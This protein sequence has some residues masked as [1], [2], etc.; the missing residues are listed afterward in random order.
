MRFFKREFSH[1]VKSAILV[2]QNN[3]TAANVGILSQSCGSW[4][5]EHEKK[6][7][8]SLIVVDVV[9]GIVADMSVTCAMPPESC[10]ENTPFCA[11]K[12]GMLG[13]YK[14]KLVNLPKKDIKEYE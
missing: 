2:F 11:V 10:F 14:E 3:E 8:N 7:C 9:V 12:F 1:D 13:Q 4:T 5:F 6:I